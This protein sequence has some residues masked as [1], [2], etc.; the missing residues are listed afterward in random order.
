[1][2]REWKPGDVAVLDYSRGS[3]VSVFTAADYWRTQE[4]TTA[5]GDLALAVRPLV[6][7]DPED[8]EQVERLVSLASHNSCIGIESWQAALREYANP[9]PPRPEEPAGLGAVVEDEDGEN[10]VRFS[11]KTGWWWRRWNG[12]NK[13]WADISAVRILSS[14]VPA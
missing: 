6:V 1:M 9:T 11:S 12:E 13:R 4:D 14:G 5:M 3:F 10:W 2:G 7:I 8:R